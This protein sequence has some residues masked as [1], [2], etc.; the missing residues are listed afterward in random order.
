MM[1]R[2][3][4]NLA[5]FA[6]LVGLLAVNW[7]APAPDRPNFEFLPQMAHAPRYGAFAANPN[8]AD[9]KTLQAPAP[10]TIPR[11]FM[12]LHYSPSPVDQVRAGEEL[13][14]PITPDNAWARQRGATVYSNY[15]ATCH[16]AT[17]AGDGPV[18]MRGFPPP[19]SLLGTKAVRMKN[20]QLFHLLTYGQGNMPP[21]ASQISR[22]DR[23][24][25][26]AYVRQMQEKAAPPP[27]ATAAEPA[28]AAPAHAQGGKP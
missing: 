10:G 27:A 4:L 22:A 2:V 5:L 9:G 6:A 8:F 3:V 11:G 19:P 18:S 21:Y 13:S 28:G 14:S 1:G 23:W 7:L 25:V 16:G 26:I 15:C 17:G 24:N 20:G 12:P